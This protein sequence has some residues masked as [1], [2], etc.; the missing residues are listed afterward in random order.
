[1]PPCTCD[2]G[3]IKHA[4]ETATSG[5]QAWLACLGLQ[6]ISTQHGGQQ[7]SQA[8]LH[9]LL[10]L[11]G[12]SEVSAGDDEAGL[13]LVAANG[14]ALVTGELSGAANVCSPKRTVREG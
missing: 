4:T 3:R 1:M 9:V 8:L 12:H 5:T 10:Q 7:G 14:D 11:G 6:H 13:P 2:Q